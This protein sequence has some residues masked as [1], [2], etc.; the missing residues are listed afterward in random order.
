MT[1]S[2]SLQ[3]IFRTE[4]TKALG[5]NCFSANLLRFLA[6]CF[7]LHH[8]AFKF[9]CSTFRTPVHWAQGDAAPCCNKCI[10]LPLL[11]RAAPDVVGRILKQPVCCSRGHGQMKY[12][13][14][15]L[16]HLKVVLSSVKQVCRQLCGY[17]PFSPGDRWPPT[18]RQ[19]SCGWC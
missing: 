3:V 7:A 2:L 5:R 13:S 17:S 14:M 9:S 8:K 12:L 16:V 10:K 1:F 15:D 11:V 6:M 18:S 4:T 19:R